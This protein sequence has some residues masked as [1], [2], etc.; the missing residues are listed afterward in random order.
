MLFH[1]SVFLFQPAEDQG[2]SSGRRPSFLIAHLLCMRVT[3]SLH[4]VEILKWSLIHWVFICTHIFLSGK[5]VYQENIYQTSCF[6]E[7]LTNQ[8]SCSR[9]SFR[10]HEP[11]QF[12]LISLAHETIVWL[13]FF[14]I[15]CLLFK[16]SLYI[17]L[18]CVFV[19]GFCVLNSKT[20]MNQSEFQYYNIYIYIF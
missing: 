16:T 12:I 5:A 15:V 19:C 10:K 17:C 4:K 9:E 3:E 20:L 18:N 1:W 14:I 8:K 6:S 11:N 2:R 7:P 13:H